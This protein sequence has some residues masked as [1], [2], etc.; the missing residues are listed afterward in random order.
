MQWAVDRGHNGCQ[1]GHTIRGAG[2][3]RNLGISEREICNLAEN[4]KFTKF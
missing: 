3:Y 1:E 2:P 4:S